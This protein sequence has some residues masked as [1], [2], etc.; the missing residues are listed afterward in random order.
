MVSLSQAEE[1]LQRVYGYP[2]FRRGQKEVIQR[3][4]HH[5]DVLGIMPTGGGKS[6]C[7]QIPA[8]LWDG[9]TIVISPL[10][11][12][13]KDQVDA[14]TQLG[15]PASYLNSTLSW[16]EQEERLA[17]L[18]ARKTKLLYIAPERL[19]S[20]SFLSL[21]QSV[22]VSL[23]TVDEAHCIS[24]WGH[25]FRPSYLKISKLLNS[26]TTRPTVVA[27]TATATEQVRQDILDHLQIPAEH[28][29]FTSF[30][31]TNLSFSVLHGVDRKE[32]L[33]RFLREHP[34]QSGIIYCATRKEVESVSSYLNDHHFSV[35]KYHAGL[36]DMERSSVQEKFSYDQIQVMVA[37]NAFG[38]GIDK[39]NVRYVIHYQMPRNIENYYQEAGRAGRDG[40]ES[41]CILL[42]QPQDVF[43]QSFLIE[44]S[45]LSEERKKWELQKLQAMKNYAHTQVCLQQ[46][47]LR[48]FGEKTEDT[49]GKCENCLRSTHSQ[50][51]EITSTAQMIFSCIRRMREKYGLSLV[52]KV[53][54][55]S[56]SKRVLEFQFDKLTTYGILQD[57]KEKEV[58]RLCQQLV[59][60]GYIEVVPNSSGFPISKL[61][62]KA[63]LVL[64]GE[65]DVYRYVPKDEERLV[66]EMSTPREQL[67]ETLRKLRLIIS[68]REK[69]PPFVIFPDSTL[70][71]M[72]RYVPTD[73][74]SMRQIKGMGEK[75]FERFGEEFLREIKRFLEKQPLEKVTNNSTS[76]NVSSKEDL[77]K[78]KSPPSHLVTYEMY[79]AGQ[80]LD[81]I[82]HE[83]NLSLSTVQEHLIRADQE[84]YS[85][86]WKPFISTDHKELIEQV[87]KQADTTKLR[88]IKEALPEEI[89]YFEIKAYFAMLAQQ[90]LEASS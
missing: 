62:P 75:R 51:E 54:V 63:W 41:E 49:C 83:R 80:T 25:D 28:L 89:S 24:Q 31:R 12:L 71:E 57:W 60:D 61:T 85:I 81:Q 39:S 43:T 1:I 44:N 79:Q 22:P 40:E 72:T 78:P 9:I 66:E 65:L 21:L 19:E 3:I 77:S 36:S 74:A 11:S 10:I 34:K 55:G 5:Q 37:T 87:T 7:Y 33:L 50:K 26:L 29:E 90:K 88:A 23:L 13:M 45:E 6:I 4:L 46:Q 16:Q 56:R 42:Y 84:G 32:Y 18:R 53:L 15:I 59:G 17:D 27:L 20:E 58:L 14:C 47:I 68:M 64:K 30:R 8:L 2:R 67:F 82:T 52:S 48:Y 69:V 38:M 73:E 86:D 76:K 70:K 35:G